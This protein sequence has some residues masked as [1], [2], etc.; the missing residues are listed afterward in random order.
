MAGVISLRTTP[1]MNSR[2]NSMQQ[3][4]TLVAEP[5]DVA[6]PL[7]QQPDHPG[8]IVGSDLKESLGRPMA[9][10]GS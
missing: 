7:D 5:S 6:M 2:N 3:Q 9:V 8:V 4:T 1:G 10:V